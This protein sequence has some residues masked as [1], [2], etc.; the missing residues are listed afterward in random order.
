ML[1]VVTELHVRNFWR[2]FEFVRLSVGSMKQAKRSA[3]N[4]HA[5][6]GN[7]GWR[8]GY[9]LTAWENKEAMLEFRNTGTHKKAMTRIRKLSAKYKTLVWEGDTIPT[10]TDAKARLDEIA[11]KELK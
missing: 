7:K 4:I 11:F 3:G 1:I 9:T 8:I 10:F 6:A 5:A 2:F